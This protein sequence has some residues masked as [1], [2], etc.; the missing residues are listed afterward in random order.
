[1]NGISGGQQAKVRCLQGLQREETGMSDKSKLTGKKDA[2]LMVFDDL[3]PV[4][5][6]D[7]FELT[8]DGQRRARRRA[9]NGIAAGE[10]LTNGKH[11]HSSNGQGQGGR[12]DTVEIDLESDAVVEVLE[13]S[14]GPANAVDA[15][16]LV[17]EGEY[18]VLS[19][20]ADAHPRGLGHAGLDRASQISAAMPEQLAEV[21]EVTTLSDVN[22]EA[23]TTPH[24]QQP[25]FGTTLRGRPV[26]PD[27]PALRAAIGRRHST[28]PTQLFEPAAVTQGA[29][30]QS[31]PAGQ[32]NWPADVPSRALEE[33]PGSLDGQGADLPSEDGGAAGEWRAK[34]G[35]KVPAEVEGPAPVAGGA[36]VVTS[37]AAPQSPFGK[38]LDTH[39][40]AVPMREAAPVKSFQTGSGQ[41]YPAQTYP[42][43]AGSAYQ[44]GGAAPSTPMASP[45]VPLPR[46][47]GS[48]IP[49][50]GSAGAGPKT[51]T[52]GLPWV[53]PRHV[54]NASTVPVPVPPFQAA[55]AL[56]ATTTLDGRGSAP[57][58]TR[59]TG[60]SWPAP[61]SVQVDETLY[62]SRRTMSRR[63]L[64]LG[65]LVGG[66][67]TGMAVWM[68]WGPPRVSR[69]GM[70]TLTTDPADAQVAVDGVPM[71]ADSSPFELI[72]NEG[73]T[74]QIQVERDGYR[75]RSFSLKVRSG[76]ELAL[77][78]VTL[79]PLEL[80]GRIDVDS[81][82]SGANVY[83]DGQDTG[84]TTPV[85]LEGYG[86]GGHM[87]RLSRAGYA[88]F[89]VQVFVTRGK[90]VQLPTPELIP[91]Q[92][93]A[94]ARPVQELRLRSR[95]RERRRSAASEQSVDGTGLL[96]LNTL[97]WS[98]VYVDG[99]SIGHTPVL[100]QPLSAGA[101]TIRLLNPE[102][103]LAKELQI[104]V[105][106]G[107]TL[108]KL[109]DLTE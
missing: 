90:T 31:Q 5:Q 16:R 3:Q 23:G 83:V 30:P 43:Q 64:L 75:T 105:K 100:E 11:S 46:Q 39:G 14:D 45:A 44:T 22:R 7:E 59:T 66:L 4:S 77:P 97:P 28:M 88:D 38:T 57:G 51:P 56:P 95:R 9:T 101:H 20:V 65:M 107:Q 62:V 108:K 32:H 85:R 71:A 96:S 18:E 1:M 8:P 37:K 70:A 36:A 61:R 42:A 17:E 103:G 13:A 15:V 50:V 48:G 41:A 60:R 63:V 99:E 52:A 76:V 93:S 92:P 54:P 80:P 58:A 81:N 84:K 82:P 19:D 2:D 34:L 89:E 94:Q 55:G 10:P 87:L 106:P 72:L 26:E 78:T 98:Q 86:E 49:L 109:I 25:T 68:G 91:V 73:R 6:L 74:Y 79:E 47:G 12:E 29:E 24:G 21:D 40:A 35:V 69:P 102:L 27:L 104:Q 67:V 33:R 53:M